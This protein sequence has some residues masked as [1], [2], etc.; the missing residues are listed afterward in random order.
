[1]KARLTYQEV[2]AYI[3]PHIAGVDYE[4]SEELLDRFRDA[5]GAGVCLPGRCLDLGRAV[6]LTLAEAGV[7]ETNVAACEASTA[8]ATDRFF[9]YRASGGRCGRHGALAVLAG[10]PGEE[11]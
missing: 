5:F 3:G 10:T 8:T 9:S 6:A 4:V 11:A 2:M 1:M 7:P